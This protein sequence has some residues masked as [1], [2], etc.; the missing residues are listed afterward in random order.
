MFPGDKGG[1]HVPESLLQK[2]LCAL[3]ALQRDQRGLG[4]ACCPKLGFSRPLSGEG[5][6]G[7][8]IA[9][10]RPPASVS[11]SEAFARC[12]PPPL[13]DFV[14]LRGGAAKAGPPPELGL[15]RH[16]RWRWLSG[17][18]S[19]QGGLR[20]RERRGRRAGAQG[21]LGAE[22]GRGGRAQPAA[23]GAHRLPARPAA[24]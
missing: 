15:A 8:R 17:V 4:E 12:C 24:A 23:G 7:R 3:G 22:P 5:P 16:W 6:C 2:R 1:Q 20:Q 13:V 19:P 11:S 21:A 9:L 10:P 18:A 14:S